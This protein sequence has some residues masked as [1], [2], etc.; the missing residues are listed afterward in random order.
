VHELHT[1]EGSPQMMDEFMTYGAQ[2]LV[3]PPPVP[4]KLQIAKKK[5]V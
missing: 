1:G 4:K 3:A 2:E 5:L